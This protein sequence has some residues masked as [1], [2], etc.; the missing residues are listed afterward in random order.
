MAHGPRKKRLDFGGNVDPDQ[1]PGIF[2]GIFMRIR[3]LD[4]NVC[5]KHINSESSGNSRAYSRERRLQPAR[6]LKTDMYATSLGGGLRS[7]S[8]SF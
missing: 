4:I 8:F 1:D 7:P 3:L 5:V 6:Y 2:N